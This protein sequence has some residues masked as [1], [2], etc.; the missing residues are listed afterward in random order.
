[1][2]IQQRDRVGRHCPCWMCREAKRTRKPET[3]DRTVARKS[4]EEVVG[5]WRRRLE[6]KQNAVLELLA[7]MP[8]RVYVEL[9]NEQSISD[10]LDREFRQF[11]PV[12]VDG[13]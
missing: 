13:E 5:T 9:R 2:T 8:Q 3:G 4:K 7:D 1:M 10:E 12:E 6:S 11:M